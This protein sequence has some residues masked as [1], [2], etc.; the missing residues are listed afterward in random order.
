MEQKINKEIEDL[1]TIN[2]DYL[3]IL[4][5]IKESNLSEKAKNVTVSIYEKQ[6]R[7]NNETIKDL[8]ERK[9]VEAH[10]SAHQKNSLL[11]K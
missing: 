2:E 1:L 11:M 10:L 6:I 4:D 3:K 7:K 8:T 5:E 9:S